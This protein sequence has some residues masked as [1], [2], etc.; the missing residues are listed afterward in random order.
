[1]SNLYGEAELLNSTFFINNSPT[2]YLECTTE[3]YINP[4]NDYYITVAN[5]PIEGY[6][7]ND[8]VNAI[9]TAFNQTNSTTR[10]NDLISSGFSLVNS[11]PT[12]TFDINNIFTTADYGIN[13]SNSVLNFF[14]NM[15]YDGINNSGNLPNPTTGF[16]F[17]GNLPIASNYS[18]P[19]DVNLN[20]IP[21]TLITIYPKPSQGN[22][23][24]DPFTIPFVYT[25]SENT[26]IVGSFLIYTSH[27]DISTDVNKSISLYL[28]QNQENVLSGTNLVYGNIIGSTY[29]P[30]IT[31]NVLKN[32]TQNGYVANLYDVITGLPFYGLSNSW[33]SYLS[34]NEDNYNLLDYSIDNQPYSQITGNLTVVGETIELFDGSNNFFYIKAQQNANGLFTTTAG[35]F[36]NSF[37]N[38][39]RIEIPPG[40]YS[41]SLQLFDA[42]NNEFT[43]NPLT[44]GSYISPIVLN[45]INYTKLRLNVN[46]IFTA[47]DFSL[48]FYDETSF[49]KCYVGDVSVRNTNWD[50]T[51]GW[52]MG[53]QLEQTYILSNYTDPNTNIATITG[54][55][56]VNVN[57]YNYLLLSLDDYNQN[58]LNDGVVTITKNQIS[59]PLPSYSSMSNFTCDASGNKISNG[60]TIVSNNN[61][62]LN[63]V[64]SLNQILNAQ[65][66][67]PKTYTTGPFVKD[68][69]AYI[70]LRVSNLQNGQTFVETSGQLQQQERMYFGPV[71]IHRLSVTLYNDKGTVLDLNKTNFSFSFVCEQLYQKQK[72]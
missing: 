24:A 70:P 57:L 69:F 61:L 44:L 2:I 60:S 33:K 52:I 14:Y 64:Y 35:N 23:N 15:T 30:I 56:S 28:D 29:T 43:N 34:F 6:L 47:N 26:K 32:L 45:N 7:L 37:Y 65:Q 10:N 25:L 19:V 41:T 58:R 8:Y 46:K 31:I 59:I 38:D 13:F 9:N 12:I 22:S 49:V 53:F 11:T 18:I 17:T 48:V 54:D 4:L 1:V 55:T 36:T 72:L 66:N 51:L 68:V 20:T 40:I 21:N 27:T 67:Q 63:Q 3:G 71:N 39:I 62:T 42:I 50:T 5:S 16:T